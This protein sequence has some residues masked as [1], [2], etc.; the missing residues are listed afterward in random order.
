ML[1][2]LR[3]AGVLACS[4]LL[5]CGGC[6]RSRPADQ[7]PEQSV[8]A[9]IALQRVLGGGEGFDRALGPKALRFP[10]DHGAHD[11]FRS[12][13][14]Y[15]TA[16]LTD[17]RGARFGIQFTVF[18]QAIAPPGTMQADADASRWRTGQLYLAHVG[19]TDVAAG[20]H[21]AFERSA[22][23]AL[24][25][26][27]AE[28]EPFRVWVDGWSLESGGQSFLPL[29]LAVR[30]RSGLS[31]ELRLDGTRPMVLQGD[32]GFSRKGREPGNASYY[33]TYT[34]LAARGV[35]ERS[36]MRLGLS[37]SAWLDREWGTS[38][39]GREHAGWD[40]FSLQLDDGRDLMVYRLRRRDGQRDPFDAGTLVQP[41]GRSE[42]LESGDFTLTPLASWTDERDVRWPLR[43]RLE[44]PGRKL[45]FEIAPVLEDQ[46][47]R[48][49]LTYWEG[50]VDVHGSAAGVGYLELTGYG[51][52]GDVE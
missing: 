35:L 24:G 38:V 2:P 23:G 16:N 28:S 48:T 33:Y 13:W 5:A 42:H 27:G 1:D 19:I 36:G 51:E 17:A 52:R 11:A 21:E 4:A 45:S 3:F 34:R 25:L 18:R 49:S 10:E 9:G 8:R 37:G 44:L 39:L 43:W 31:L 15:L 40:W 41:D 6:Q 32:A 47:M 22:R 29:R 12:E 20:R 7:F 26:A 50:A 46:L 14:W 30:T